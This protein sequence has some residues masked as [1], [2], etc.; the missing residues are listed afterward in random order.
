MSSPN[1][2][3]A[4]ASE[5]VNSSTGKQQ[6]QLGLS[7]VSPFDASSP[8]CP[9]PTAPA[10]SQY[11][12][13]P[14]PPYDYNEVAHTPVA[15]FSPAAS[16]LRLATAGYDVLRTS[17]ID[18]DNNSEQIKKAQKW[19]KWAESALNFDDVPTAL[20]NLKRAIQELG[21]E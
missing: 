4:Q 1:P 9:P 3:E 19:I 17:I 18:P 14:F 5:E 11:A 15:S 10:R 7:S 16:M 21:G 12:Q 6:P 20:K 2:A 13:Q 8:T